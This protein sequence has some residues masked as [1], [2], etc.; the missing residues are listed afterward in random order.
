MTCQQFL[1][2]HSDFLDG[3]MDF[4]EAAAC[5]AHLDGCISCARFH[6]AVTRSLAL[7]GELPAV[8]PS[9]DFQERLQHRLLHLQDEMSRHDRFAGSGALASLAIS[10]FIA[11]IAWG[12]L[13]MRDAARPG[14]ARATEPENAPNVADALPAGTAEDFTPVDWYDAVPGM[15]GLDGAASL[16][17]AFPGPYSPL[18]VEAPVTRVSRR[19]ARAV[20]AA[21]YPALE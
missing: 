20:F 2:R 4:E 1:P 21:Y 12:P 13:M 8:Q 5:Q 18:I 7:V 11:L 15:I 17:T 14:Q 19:A 9:P 10:A 16:S 3:V 6:T